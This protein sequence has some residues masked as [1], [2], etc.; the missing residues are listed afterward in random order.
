MPGPHHR[1][2]VGSRR[3]ARAIQ[4]ELANDASITVSRKMRFIWN[5]LC[6]DEDCESNLEVR[7]TA[8]LGLDGS[9]ADQ[10]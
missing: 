9:A 2:D 10:R 4:S 5:V 1:L 3:V 8:T 6:I 7:S